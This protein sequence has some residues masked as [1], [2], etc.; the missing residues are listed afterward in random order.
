MPNSLTG[1]FIIKEVRDRKPNEFLFGCSERIVASY[2]FTRL[3]DFFRDQG[4]DIEFMDER[5][6]P[7]DYHG[8]RIRGYVITRK[9]D[10]G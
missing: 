5:C 4:W 6:L 2:E 9:K 1:R 3:L 7:K 8:D 10:A